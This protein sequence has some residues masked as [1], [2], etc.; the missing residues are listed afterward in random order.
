MKFDENMKLALGTVQFGGHYGVAN[1]GQRVS[2]NE[3][4]VI[5]ERSKDLGINVLDTAISYG[6]SQTVLGDIGVLDWCIITKLPAVPDNCDDVYGWVK[7]ELLLSLSKLRVSR[8]YGLMLHRPDQLLSRIGPELFQ[9]LQIIKSEGFVEKI[10]ISVYKPSEIENISQIFQLDIIQ[11][12]LNVID[13]RIQDSG[14][15]EE[16]KK[17]G[18]ELHTRSS[19]LQGLLLMPAKNR[20]SKFDRWEAF[21]KEW[22]DWL[23]QTGLTRLQACFGYL[24]SL[25]FVDRIVVGVDSV[26]QLNEIVEASNTPMIDI[27][28]FSAL[29]DKKLINPICWNE[30]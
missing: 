7:K 4:A 15:G 20:P 9:A 28:E 29:S 26:Q 14:W 18:I 3:A 24:N 16:C 12:P 21:W 23:M 27:P 6:D 22:E 1:H 5:L 19:F 13:R 25:D 11:A 30:L 8:I 17:L 10:G 2:S